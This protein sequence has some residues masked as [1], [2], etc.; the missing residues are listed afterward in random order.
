MMIA[1]IDDRDPDVGPGQTLRCRQAAEAGTDNDHVMRHER[2]W[3]SGASA[4]MTE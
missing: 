3:E 1:S 4:V 2:S